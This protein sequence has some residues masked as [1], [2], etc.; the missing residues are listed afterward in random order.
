MEILLSCL[1]INLELLNCKE[2]TTVKSNTDFQNYDGYI[3][4][5][6]KSG[7]WLEKEGSSTW[8]VKTEKELNI[9]I[10]GGY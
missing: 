5:E 6:E 2:I 1:V 10:K 9:L 8:V 4:P 3:Y 7:P